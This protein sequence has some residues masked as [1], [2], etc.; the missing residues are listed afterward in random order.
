MNAVGDE[1]IPS[2]DGLGQVKQH[3]EGNV[4]G[5]AADLAEEVV[6]VGR[7]REVDHPGPVA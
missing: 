1:G 5:A 6:M 4:D 7:L 2:L 3:A